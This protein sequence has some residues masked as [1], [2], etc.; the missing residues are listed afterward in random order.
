V[1]HFEVIGD[2][3]RVRMVILATLLDDLPVNLAHADLP[4][5]H[6]CIGIHPCEVHHAPDDATARLAAFAGEPRVCAIG[7]NC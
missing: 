6:A 2:S 1:V 7:E 5:V 4:G 3:G